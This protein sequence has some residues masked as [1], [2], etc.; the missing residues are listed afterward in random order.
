M[1]RVSKKSNVYTKVNAAMKKEQSIQIYRTALYARL[2]I[3]DNGKG[4][5][6][7]EAQLQFLHNYIE[8]KPQFDFCGDFTDNGFT[9]TNY[10]RPGFQEMIELVQAGKIDC[11]IV[12]DLSRLGRNYIETGNFIEKICPM[13][14]LRLIAINDN[15]DTAFKNSSSDMS[16]SVMN[17]ANDM[18]A[19]DISRKICSAMQGKIERGE[20]IGNYAPYGYLKDPENKNH[21]I[22]DPVLI[23]MVNRIFEMRASGM[24]IGSIATILNNEDVP[25]PGRYRYENGIITNNNKKGTGLLWNRHVLTDLLKN[26]VYIGNLAQARSKSA[27]YKGIPFHWTAEEEWIVVENTHEGIVPKELFRR[28][29]AVN[30]HNSN[31]QK[32]NFG[33]YSYLPK[34]VNIYGKCLVCADCGSVIKLCRSISTKKDKAYFTF[35]CP[36]FVEHRERGCSD[37]SISQAEVDEVVLATIQAHIKLFIKHKEV[38]VKLQAK[39]QRQSQHYQ[40]QKEMRDMEKKIQQRESLRTGLYMD[41]K[42]GLIDEGEYEFSKASYSQEI[43]ELQQHLA[44]LE[45]QADAETASLNR[46]SHWIYLIDKY[47][48]VQEL[49]KEVVEAFVQEIKLYENK[50]IEITLNYMDE[51]R[52]A[53]DIYKKRR[54]EIA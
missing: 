47:S 31:A 5:D 3:E 29:Q 27:L 28:V 42:D 25:S 13:L 6:S 48:T 21:L 40:L 23:P 7:L 53:M 26:V 2:S 24:G 15:Y 39:D 44:E 49:N 1:A 41:L 8:G 10:N 14:S 54:K 20:Y 52:A 38:I 33:K 36:M 32:S 37:K 11:I 19:K 50:K 46:Y 17:I 9:G 30:Q 12:K 43:R 18:Y 4:A 51:F 16:M 22:P 45:A 34:A 35:K